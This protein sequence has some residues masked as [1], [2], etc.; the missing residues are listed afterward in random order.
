MTRSRIG[1]SSG[2]ESAERSTGGPSSGAGRFV[3]D[4]GA[5]ISTA[6]AG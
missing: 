1:V 5:M 2:N 4:G 6:L 3:S